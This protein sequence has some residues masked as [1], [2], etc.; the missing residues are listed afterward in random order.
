MGAAG[1]GENIAT[2]AIL[3]VNEQVPLDLFAIEIERALAEIGACISCRSPINDMPPVFDQINP[4]TLS[5]DWSEHALFE[6][7]LVWLGPT[8]RLTRQMV[9]L[10]SGCNPDSLGSEGGT[11]LTDWLGT[12]VTQFE[13]VFLVASIF[14]HKSS[15]LSHCL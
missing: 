6:P 9:H 10:N 2:V 1:G 5:A 14:L 4:C 15:R 8:L 7:W 11:D 13:E 12:Q 3:P